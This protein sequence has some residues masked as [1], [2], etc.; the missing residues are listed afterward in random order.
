MRNKMRVLCCV[1][2]LL[3]V[4]GSRLVDASQTRRLGGFGRVKFQL[5]QTEGD[6]SMDEKQQIEWLQR[7]KAA[8][9][10]GKNGVK[11]KVRDFSPISGKTLQ[12]AI[13]FVEH[14]RHQRILTRGV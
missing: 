13:D 12:E 6:F 4:G 10:F 2:W 9:W 14:F 3:P 11:V 7:E 8:V 1:G 5:V